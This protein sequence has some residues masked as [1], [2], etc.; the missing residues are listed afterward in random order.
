[1]AG[2]VIDAARNGSDAGFRKQEIGKG[3][4][5]ING[6]SNSRVRPEQSSAIDERVKGTSRCDQ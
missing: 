1:M 4:V 3:D 2:H 5:V 6:G